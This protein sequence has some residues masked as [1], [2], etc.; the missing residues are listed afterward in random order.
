MNS[1]ITLT[2]IIAF[3]RIT[4]QKQMIITSILL[5]LTVNNRYDHYDINLM[6]GKPIVF[7]TINIV[8]TIVITY[9]YIYH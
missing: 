9:Q 7:V 6:Q 4:G 8:V 5:N 1:P 3:Y 2:L